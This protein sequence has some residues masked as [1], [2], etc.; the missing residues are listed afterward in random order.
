MILLQCLTHYFFQ[1]KKV[2]KD[3]KTD[4]SD[5][6]TL[7]RKNTIHALIF[8]TQNN[9]KT[10]TVFLVKDIVFAGGVFEY[11]KNIF[12]H[13]VIFVKK[14][15]ELN[16]DKYDIFEFKVGNLTQENVMVK[17]ESC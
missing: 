15:Q 5:D 8:H 2:N 10:Y 6:I 9:N 7:L 1:K 11:P 17:S 13:F 3:L 14:I 16:L 12:G 4:F